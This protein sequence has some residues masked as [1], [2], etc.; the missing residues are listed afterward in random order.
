MGSRRRTKPIR[1][2]PPK[3]APISKEDYD[4]AVHALA[5]MIAEWWRAQNNADKSDSAADPTRGRASGSR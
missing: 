3:T 4:Q 1:V 5:S 2:L